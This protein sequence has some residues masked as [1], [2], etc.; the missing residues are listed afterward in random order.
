MEALDC[1]KVL[2]DAHQSLHRTDMAYSVTVNDKRKHVDRHQQPTIGQ[3][4]Y[5]F[6]N[7]I[8]VSR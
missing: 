2:H 5:T 1:D 4:V 3:V 8:K 6:L 7:N